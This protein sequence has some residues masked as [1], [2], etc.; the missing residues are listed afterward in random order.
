MRIHVT[1]NKNSY[2]SDE[3]DDETTISQT[4]DKSLDGELSHPLTPQNAFQK[5][6]GRPTGKR[7]PNP[8][9]LGE[10]RGAFSKIKCT[11][12]TRF[13]WKRV[14]EYEGVNGIFKH[15]GDM[16]SCVEDRTVICSRLLIHQI[17]T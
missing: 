4:D 2:S 16:Y 13:L 15:I 6:F 11:E 9:L 1:R 14:Q 5:A 10:L 8:T 12:L 7:N 3:T 17:F